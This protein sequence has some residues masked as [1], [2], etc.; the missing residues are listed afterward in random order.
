[1]TGGN[2]AA[3][4]RQQTLRATIDWSYNLLT[5]A[6]QVLFT[7]LTVFAVNFDLEAAEAVCAGDHIGPGQVVEMLLA[8]VEK[9][10]VIAD[11]DEAG[12]RRYRLP[13]TLREYGRERLL[14]SGQSEALHRRH[15]A[16][17]LALV[18]RAEPELDGSRQADWIRRLGLEQGEIRAALEW[19]EARGEVQEALR[20]AGAM[21][22]FW[23]I[24]GHLREGRARL[25]R[26]LTLPG[27]SA[28]TVAR[29]RALDG[30][31]VLAMYQFD[32]PAARA[33]FRESLA[34][35]RQHQHPPGV[36]WV[37]IHLGWLCHDFARYKAARRFLREALATCRG[38]DDR[39]GVARSLTI[40]GMVE[41]A[42]LELSPARSRLE[43][44]LALTR[45]IGDRWGTAWTLDILGRVGLAEAE[46]GV[47]DAHSA[48]A[49]LEESAAIWREL[50]ERRHLAY[51]TSDLAACSAEDGHLALARAQLSEALATFTDL[52]DMGGKVSALWRCAC[53]FTTEERYLQSAL[54]LGAVDAAER[55][56]G[57]DSWC[58]ALLAEHHLESLR[59]QVD[60]ELVS[61]AFSE[62]GSLPIDDAVALAQREL[63]RP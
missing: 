59:C 30:A 17:Y 27:S 20:L 44:S 41:L 60:A 32:V 9:S 38:A 63:E 2:R 3:L 8:L 25:A 51:S 50:G 14:D 21:S 37:L 16:Y 40:L 28:A 1:M 7:S 35:Y 22:R 18:E 52:Q 19:L 23:E 56:A 26:L 13:D 39:R 12:V 45:E 57:K 62:G 34:L 49:F 46:L 61:T 4:P 47:A 42:E 53:L 36:A 15:A 33:L 29:A 10:L 31:A 6:E 58:C 48:Q 5:E 55:G 43:Q 24:R 11:E 54:M